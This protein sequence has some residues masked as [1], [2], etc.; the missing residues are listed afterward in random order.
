MSKYDTE[1]FL[2]DLFLLV[3][4]NLNGKINEI[5]AE[6]ATLLGSANFAVP[7]L[8][9]KAWFDSLDDKTANFDPYVYYGVNDNSVIQ[10]S[11]AEG[12]SLTAFFTVVLHYNGDDASMYKKMLRYIRALQEIVSENFDAFPEAGRM[13]VSAINPNDMKDLDGNTFHKIGGIMIQAGIV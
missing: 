6:K 1:Q 12:N 8:D 3:K 5:Q 11:S 2:N 4:S 13:T 9:D 7:T 10:I